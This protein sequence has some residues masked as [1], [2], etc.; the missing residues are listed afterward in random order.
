MYRNGP[1]PPKPAGSQV[2]VSPANAVP[3]LIVTGWVGGGGV[4]GSRAS[5]VTSTSVP[6]PADMGVAIASTC[7]NGSMAT[8]GWLLP[9][10]TDAAF[11]TCWVAPQS[12]PAGR[13]TA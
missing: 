6:N 3:G 7:P 10:L 11:D 12:S 8:C 1:V 13:S 5:S 9:P 2:T 4:A